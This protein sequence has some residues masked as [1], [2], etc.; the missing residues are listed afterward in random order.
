MG[1]SRRRGPRAR[2]PGLRGHPLQPCPLPH[3]Q[4]DRRGRPRPGDL[5]ARPHRRAP[6]HAGHQSQG[7]ALPD[8]AQHVPQPVSPRA[9]Q[10]HRG[11]ARHGGADLAGRGADAVAPGRSRAGP[12]AQ[13]R[14]RGDRARAHESR[15][16][17]AHR[18]P[19]GSRGADRG[20]DRPGRGLPGRDREVP[21]VT[22]ARGAAR[23]AQGLRAMT[24]EE[25]RDR[26]LDAQRARLAPETRPALQAHLQ[27]CAACTHEEAAEALLSEALESRLPQHAAPVALKR[28]LAAEWSGAPAAAPVPW[29]RWARYLVPA[30]AVAAV[31]LIGVPLVYQ[32]AAERASAQMV[33]EAVN[34]HLRILS[35]RHP[36]DIESGGIHQVKPWFEGRLDFA[37]VVRFD[38]DQD[39][40]LRGGAVG[41][42]LDRKAAVFVFN[43]RLHT[44]SLFV[45]RADGLPWPTRGLRRV[46]GGEAHVTTSRGFTS[47]LWRDGELGYALVSDVDPAELARLAVKIAGGA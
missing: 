5:R 21:A 41:Y 7:L 39:F 24:C 46:G 8:P 32:R 17:G 14:G 45:F 33:A 2:G 29:R 1:A 34:D 22:G 15:R 25:A 36:L 26:L 42:Y 38:G 16:G 10:P 3:P 37:P 9:A 23:A 27:T 28:R 31:L 30:A 44:I 18:G 20:R 19:A 43:R 47:V 6:V 12:P 35:S 40:P 13:G 11:R 4:P